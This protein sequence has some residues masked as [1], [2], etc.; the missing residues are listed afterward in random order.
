MSFLAQRNSIALGVGGVISLGVP[1]ET[2]PF[3]LTLPGIQRWYD[4]SDA[5]TVTLV[6]SKVSQWNDKTPNAQ[7]LTQSNDDNRYT[8]STASVNGLNSML[9]GGFA[10]DQ[11]MLLPSELDLT[12]TGWAVVVASVYQDNRYIALGKRSG[13]IFTNVVI[14][15]FGGSNNEN[16]ICQKYPDFIL[17]LGTGMSDGG[18]NCFVYRN[19]ATAAK[20]FWNGY[21]IASGTFGSNPGPIVIEGTTYSSEYV[22]LGLN[23]H[24]CEVM[25]GVGE[26][27]DAD[28]AAIQAYVQP[29]WGIVP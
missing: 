16:V 24:F 3:P 23:S 8:Y 9:G 20:L 25:L 2:T 5:S 27:T 1:Q 10:L 4:A 12:T 29:K 6:G 11:H 21:E 17:G 13:N 19:I 28:V 18:P 7:H 26:L 22:G 15:D 14:G